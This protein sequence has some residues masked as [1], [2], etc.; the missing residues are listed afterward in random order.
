MKRIHESLDRLLDLLRLQ[1]DPAAALLGRRIPC[2]T[3]V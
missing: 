3:A 1:R 2:G